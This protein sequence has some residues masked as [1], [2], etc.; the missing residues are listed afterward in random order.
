MVADGQARIVDVSETELRLAMVRAGVWLTFVVCISGSAYAFA[1]WDQPSRPYILT[2][3]GLGAA[4]GVLIAVLPVDRIVR[5]RFGEPFFLVW[6]ILDIALIAL[7][8][9]A[10]GGATSP[11]AFVFFLPLIFAAL[12]YPLYIFVPVGATDALAWVAVA[13]PTTTDSTHV[14]IFTACLGSTAVMCAWQAQNHDRQRGLLNLVSRS[15]PLTRC[16][17]RR[18]FEERVEAELAHSRRTGRPLALML[19]D[20]D[21]FKEINDKHGHAAGDEL[22]SWVADTI[23]ST[24]RPM[25][26]VGRLGGDEFAVLYPG[27]MGAD[28][29]AI[30]ERVRERV[31]QRIPLATGIASFPADGVDHER[32]YHQ[33]DLQLYEMK[34]GSVAKLSP[35]G[36]ELGW[37]ATLA[38]AVNARMGMPAEHSA[39]VRYATGIAR[40]LGWG[41][42]DLDSLRLAALIHDIGKVPVPDRIL[43]KEGPLDPLEFEEVKQHPVRGA[44]M[45]KRVQGLSPIAH[46]VRH[47]HEDY[48]GSGYP[49]SLRAEAIPLASRILRVADAF[50][51]MISDRSYRPALTTDEAVEQLR[52]NS[53]RHFDPQCVEVFEAYLIE[54]TSFYS[55]GEHAG[56]HSQR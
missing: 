10:D 7:I 35:G 34:H 15:D 39:V 5:G 26:V 51:A 2:L 50:D 6:S 13:A 23:R 3:L 21:G 43:Q 53:G 55:A 42:D 37:A 45:V 36:P 32:L 25:D 8:V 54:E 20:L 30:V 4:A 17:N 19:M 47:S 27:V 29:D 31:A 18:G 41:G 33:A 38:G 48:D 1:S 14:A 22:L 52:R 44:E 24:V 46:W 49:D 40:R 9:A 11:F 28:A 16:L 56:S 12:F